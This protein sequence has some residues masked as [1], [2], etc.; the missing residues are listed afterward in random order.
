MSADATARCSPPVGSTPTSSAGR[1][2]PAATER[3]GVHLLARRVPARSP[4]SGR[5]PAHPGGGRGAPP[6]PTRPASATSEVAGATP[7]PELSWDPSDHPLDPARARPRDGGRPLT[8]YE[9]WTPLET[10]PPRHPAGPDPRAGRSW[11]SRTTSTASTS[12][13]SPSAARW[14]SEPARALSSCRALAATGSGPS[15]TPRAPT[16]P[17][18]ATGPT[19]PLR[20]R[21]RRGAERDEPRLQ[22]RP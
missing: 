5:N 14:G 2:K 8:T 13:T 21:R 3:G 9:R 1:P 16:A 20:L 11:T 15:P 4:G 22:P 12:T 10:H 19:A 6:C 17:S 7:A 18:G